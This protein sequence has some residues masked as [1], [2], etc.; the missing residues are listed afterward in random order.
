MKAAVLRSD[1]PRV[2][3][4]VFDPGEEASRGL[5]K[6]A[7]HFSLSGASFT[8]IGALSSAELGY[9]DRESKDYKSIPVN[10]QVEVLA[11]TGNIAEHGD[12]LK[13]HAHIVAG[14]RDGSVVGGHLLGGK[15]WPTLEIVLTEPGSDLTRVFDEEIQLPL[16]DLDKNDSVQEINF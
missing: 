12:E 2:I 10:E 5:H 13:V 9:F 8:G 4:L 11:L 6:A 7:A 16:I 1:W 3:A 15:V 14:K